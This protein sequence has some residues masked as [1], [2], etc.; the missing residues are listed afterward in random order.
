MNR[1]EKLND[2]LDENYLKYKTEYELLH[3]HNHPFFIKDS[4][5]ISEIKKDEM[6]LISHDFI[7][8]KKS[9]YYYYICFSDDN[10]DIKTLLKYIDSECRYE[11][12]SNVYLGED[13]LVDKRNE[14]YIRGDETKYINTSLKITVV[15]IDNIYLL[16]NLIFN[17]EWGDA[18]FLKEQVEKNATK[19]YV[20]LNESNLI[21]YANFNM[22]SEK[23]NNKYNIFDYFIYTAEQY[24]N[25]GYA[26]L[27]LIL[28]FR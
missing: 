2:F 12:Y 27:L 13:N 23:F 26:F 21:S 8:P 17:N 16:D 25:K 15:D 7:F 14:Y 6:Y 5:C 22:N 1:Y 19:I 3:S 10:F 28:N 18:E 20:L 9:K 4:L 24:R 11:I